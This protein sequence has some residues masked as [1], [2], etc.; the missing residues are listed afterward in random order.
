[1]ANEIIC[2]GRS[3]TTFRD[4]GREIWLLAICL[5]ALFVV[6]PAAGSSRSPLRPR[7]NFVLLQTDDQARWDLGV[8]NKT[9]ALIAQQGVS[10]T[11]YMVNTPIC[12]PSRAEI[13]SGRYFHNVGGPGGSCMHVDAED[14][15]FNEHSLFSSLQ[16]AGYQT[17]AFGKLTN[18]Q[19]H[20]FCSKKRADGLSMIGSPC[21]VGVYYPTKYFIKLPNGTK[22]FE[23]L[24]SNDPATY[25]TAQLGNR[26]INWI[27]QLAGNSPLAAPFFAYIG[28]HA[29]HL[30]AEPAPWEEEDRFEGITAPRTPSWNVSCPDKHGFIAKNPPL[31]ENATDFLDQQHRDRHMSLLAV[32]DVIKA[33]YTTLE[34]LDLLES[35][36]II[37]TSDH[38]YHLGQWRVPSSKRLPYD[39]DIFVNTFIRGPGIKPG[40]EQAAM[41]GN[42]DIA[43]TILDLAGVEIPPLMDGK[44]MAQLIIS[45]DNPYYDLALRQQAVP[46]REAYLIQYHMTSANTNSDAS[47][48]FPGTGVFHG[49]QLYPP[50]RPCKT[51]PPWM[52]DGPE[53]TYRALRLRNATHNIL[54]AEFNVHF[55]FSN[56]SAIFYEFYDVTED[57]YQVKNTY[58]SVPKAARENYRSQLETFSACAGGQ[59][60]LEGNCP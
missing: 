12:C 22:Y 29:P 37:T 52:L 3:W 30:P 36:Y 50:A 11:N 42:T 23:N 4:I 32:D 49:T 40:S 34:K 26:T 41:V 21:N 24:D 27:T 28:P 43:P 7:P 20:F 57:P 58:G 15:V 6:G 19:N 47:M 51:C 44:S 39:T 13:F 10:F 59:G 2:Q 38:G 46:W 56:A 18:D 17:G 1:M 55:D 48:W 33:V 8:M 45:S 25:L 16:S 31:D 5:C 35:T 14:A 54:Y 9:V 53:N 60:H